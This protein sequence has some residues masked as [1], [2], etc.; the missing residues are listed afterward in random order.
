M[1]KDNKLSLKKKMSTV[2]TMVDDNDAMMCNQEAQFK[3]DEDCDFSLDLTKS[4][5]EEE[6]DTTINDVTD[7]GLRKIKTLMTERNE[8]ARSR[9]CLKYAIESGKYPTWMKFHTYNSFKVNNEADT[10]KYNELFESVAKEARENVTKSMI[11]FLEREINHKE[12][13]MKKV[14]KE[15]FDSFPLATRGWLQAKI[16]MD[17][18]IQELR[19]KYSKELIE[20]KQDLAQKS[21]RKW[22]SVR[23][24]KPHKRGHSYRGYRGYYRGKYH[25]Y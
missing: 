2:P 8:L 7:K 24:G 14:R 1:N 18:S 21:N 17:K 9:E 11:Q 15:I 19:S 6:I 4:N 23:G 20:F 25:P 3:Y 13:N 22:E 5:E 12:E 10:M 16:E